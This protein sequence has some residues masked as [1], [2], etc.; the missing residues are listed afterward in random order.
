METQQ[1]WCLNLLK[2]K[3]DAEKHHLKRYVNFHH[4]HIIQRHSLLRKICSSCLMGN[5]ETSWKQSSRE[6]FTIY[7]SK[8]C[9]F[10]FQICVSCSSV[11]KTGSSHIW[12][13]CRSSRRH[14]KGIRCKLSINWKRR[15]ELYF[16][17]KI[18]GLTKISKRKQT[19]KN[20]ETFPSIL[21]NEIYLQMTQHKILITITIL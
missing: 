21:K 2:S 17:Q 15:K 12:P 14:S 16:L 3:L 8:S 10:S 9:V 5:N 7:L 19:K 6:T 11:Y 20:P 4:M 13:I 1:C 18:L